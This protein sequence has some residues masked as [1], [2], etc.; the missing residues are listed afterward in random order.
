MANDKK[1]KIQ[2][3][4][5]NGKEPTRICPKCGLEKPLSDFGYRKMTGTGELRNQSWC[6]SCR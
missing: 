4:G 5:Y 1:V 2:A 6:K 3:E